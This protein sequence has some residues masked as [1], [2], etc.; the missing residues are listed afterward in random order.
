M[1]STVRVRTPTEL[2]DE[3]VRGDT[4][5]S[6]NNGLQVCGG[7]FP[8]FFKPPSIYSMF[9]RAVSAMA[10]SGYINICWIQCVPH[11]DHQTQW[12]FRANVSE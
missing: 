11:S 5:R 7:H 9:H 10:F 12:H 8:L 1:R 6:G 4:A 2:I 3:S